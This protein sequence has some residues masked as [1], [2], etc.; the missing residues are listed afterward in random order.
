MYVGKKDIRQFTIS[1]EVFLGSLAQPRKLWTSN[2]ANRQV[3][4]T[5]DNADFPLLMSHNEEPT[6]PDTEGE[7]IQTIG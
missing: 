3:Y 7:E 6:Q 4:I 1:F 5:G 2:W